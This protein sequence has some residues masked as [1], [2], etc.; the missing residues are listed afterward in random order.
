M[1][2]YMPLEIAPGF[3]YNG[4]EM[5]SRNRWRDG[6]LVRFEGVDLRPIGGWTNLQRDNAGTAE[7][8][9]FAAGTARQSH[10]WLGNDQVAYMAVG[11][12]DNLYAMGVTLTM[13]DKTPVGFTAGVEGENLGYGGKAFGASTYGTERISD[14][15]S[16]P[17]TI[18]SMDNWG[19]ELLCCTTND[20]TLYKWDLGVGVATEI[21]NAP[22]MNAMFVTAERF[23]FALGADSNP[24]KIAWCDREDYDTWTAASTNE[25]GD[26]EIVTRGDLQAGCRVRGRALILTQYDAHVATYRGPP[27]VYGFQ[28]VGDGVGIAAP[29]T[30]VPVRGG[31]F[32]M[33][34]NGFF[35]YDGSSAQ[36]IPC[37]V[38]DKVFTT[39]NDTLIRRAWGVANQKH[40]EVWWFYPSGEST[41]CDKYVA[42]DYKE[43]V[44]ITGTLRR[45]SGVDRGAFSNPIWIDENRDLLRHEIGYAH[46]GSDPWAKTGPIWVGNGD[47]VIHA[48]NLL[49]DELITTDFT[50]TTITAT[51]E[52]RFWPD[53]SAVSHGPYTL[54]EPTNIR[55]TGR[56]FTMRLDATDG[57]DWRIG[58][59]RLEYS[60]QGGRR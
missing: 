49:Q 60:G 26:I 51:F 50:G 54:G 24:R 47:E 31:A 56:Q 5:N 27:D 21:V 43:G 42:F 18:W 15:T 53:D 13:A 44:W 37:D 9:D 2:I 8:V 55:W 36:E 48:V 1:P 58:N 29:R 30:L 12:K 32:W 34:R 14:G 45:D 17:E 39:I 16:A 57:A 3:H 46:D 25:A 22:S 59:F 35:A 33:G 11:T 7:D 4:P 20:N 23:V 28:K 52:T 19:Q 10:A 40:N 41:E 38:H 6:N